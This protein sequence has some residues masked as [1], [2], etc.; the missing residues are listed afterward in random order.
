M[1]Y[2]LM[3]RASGPESAE[4]GVDD[5][6]V[7][8]RSVEQFDERLAKAGVLLAGERLA[9]DEGVVVDC[10][11]DDD[12][13]DYGEHRLVDS[14]TAVWIVQVASREEAM[15]WARRSP[16]RRG[17]IEVHRVLELGE[18][19]SPRYTTPVRGA[20]WRHPVE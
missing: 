12:A 20:L 18:T 7:G 13:V 1:K 2:L 14:P 9:P 5:S 6:L 16:L 4:G 19:G 8:W 3:L 11:G 10:T 17:R 15:E